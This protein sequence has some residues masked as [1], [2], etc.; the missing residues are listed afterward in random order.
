LPR[1]KNDAVKREAN[2]IN[3]TIGSCQPLA[4]GPAANASVLGDDAATLDGTAWL[5]PDERAIDD[6]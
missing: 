1:L 2:T 6:A 3:L 4:G 5:A